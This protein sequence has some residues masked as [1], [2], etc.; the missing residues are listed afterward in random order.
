MRSRKSIR[1]KTK[2]MA[3]VVL[4]ALAALAGM[5]LEFD[6]MQSPDWQFR[7]SKAVEGYQWLAN[8]TENDSVVLAWWDY[9][10]GIE[11][12]G[13]RGVVIREASQKS[14]YYRWISRS[15]EAVA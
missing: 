4:V 15:W 10:D 12:M 1:S 2:G 9:A 7:D 3:A 6:G 8:N 5:R 14:K 13:H 11:K